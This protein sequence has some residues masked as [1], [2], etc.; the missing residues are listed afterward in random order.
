MGRTHTCGELRVEN[1]GQT[2][3]LVGWVHDFMVLGSVTYADLRDSSGI[4]QLVVETRAADGLIDKADSVGG[5][6]VQ[7]TGEVVARNT[8]NPD[9]ETGDIEVRVMEVKVIKISTIS[10]KRLIWAYENCGLW[11]A[12]KWA[13]Y[14]IIAI[15]RFAGYCLTLPFQ[16]IWIMLT[17]KY[18]R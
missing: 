17:G 6:W 1:V 8:K 14:D 13:G 16:F 3:T 9:M 18:K 4:T 11:M 12:I 10:I 2:V 7:V 15:L 5:H